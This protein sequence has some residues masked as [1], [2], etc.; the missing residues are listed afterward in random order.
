MLS[1]FSLCAY[2][3]WEIK[4]CNDSHSRLHPLTNTH[5]ASS[6]LRWHERP[7]A[8]VQSHCLAPEA[9]RTQLC[10]ATDGTPCHQGNGHSASHYSL[11]CFTLFCLTLLCLALLFTLL[12]TTQLRTTVPHSNLCTTLP[13]TTLY[14]T[15]HATLH[16]LVHESNCSFLC[17]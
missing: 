3:V 10:A 9:P 14:T 7:H 12:C 5:T 17:W 15:L 16:C 1:I 6:A 13:H 11:L 8:G 4:L 2:S